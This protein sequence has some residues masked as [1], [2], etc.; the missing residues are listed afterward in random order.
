MVS[1]SG[2]FKHAQ[3][4]L[5]PK[6]DAYMSGLLCDSVPGGIT[7]CLK[8]GYLYLCPK[9]AYKD[10]LEKKFNVAL[11]EPCETYGINI[12]EAN[13][14]QIA[15]YLRVPNDFCAYCDCKTAYTLG[16]RVNPRRSAD[17]DVSLYEWIQE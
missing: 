5:E 17:E 2:N 14:E 6:N 9:M 13:A 10:N 12:F 3:L 16:A 7:P 8:E 15:N 1:K 4:N 11:G